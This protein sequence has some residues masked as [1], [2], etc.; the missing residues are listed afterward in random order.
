MKP[1]RR[2]IEVSEA[3][4]R[5]IDT[6]V[7]VE[8]TERVGLR[9]SA[10]RVLAEVVQSD[11]MVPAFT[12]SAMDGYAVRA[13]DT[14]K[15]TKFEHA[16]LGLKGNVHAGSMPEG[17]VGAGTCFQ[18][19]TGAPIPLGADAVVKV[20]DTSRDGADVLLSRP[21]HPG[22]NVAPAGEDIQPGD[23]VLEE[24]LHLTPSRIG[25]AA[26]LG[27]LE[28]EVYR[29]PRALIYTTGDEVHPLGE[30][31]P[32]GKVYDIN[33]YTVGALLDEYGIVWEKGE[34]VPDDRSSIEAAIEGGRHFDLV[35]FSGGS[36]AG[37]RDLLV[38]IIA[39][40]GEVV[41]HGV[42]MKPGK[43]TIFAKVGEAL[44]FGLPGFPASC[45]A[46]AQVLLAPCV[47]KMAHL[48][49]LGKRS[50]KRKLGGKISS[51]LGRHQFY[52][53]TVKGDLVYPAYKESGDITS[54]SA[55]D[56]YVEIPPTVEFL[57]AG[58]EV[59]VV[60]Y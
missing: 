11:V 29:R 20:E 47:R 55:S 37:E 42:A 5:V 7:P 24:G 36:S 3:F 46:V 40:L 15:A 48:P 18:I 56:G 27:R 30:P 39:E 32:P 52:T 19:A 50:V 49:P 34:N 54:L 59:E 1:L 2:L 60:L 57:E 41:F 14:F 10:G 28:L 21:V 35:L 4:K 16:R 12:R 38:H 25:A 43:P 17:S 9:E 6:T 51:T 26:A 31:L 45:L 33:S 13:E 58:E 44:L 22:Q 8:G 23:T 53:V